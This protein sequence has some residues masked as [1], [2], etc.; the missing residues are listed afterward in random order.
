MPEHLNALDRELSELLAV[1]PS[2]EFAAK[3]RTRIER[4]PVST[5]SWRYWAGPRWRPR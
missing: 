2:P 4:E 1:E 5:F 3:V